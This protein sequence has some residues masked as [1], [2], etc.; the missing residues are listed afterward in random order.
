[1]DHRSLQSDKCST[2]TVLE[3]A[4]GK[5][6]SSRKLML[7]WVTDNSNALCLLHIIRVIWLA[8]KL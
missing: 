2:S 4:L 6:Q 5:R 3:I 7:V 1:M 8:N